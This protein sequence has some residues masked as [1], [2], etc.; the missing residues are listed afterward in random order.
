M[1]D[2]TK[3]KGKLVSILI[4]GLKGNKESYVGTI[5]DVNDDFIDLKC[6]GGNQKFPIERILIKTSLVESVW[7]Y[8]EGYKK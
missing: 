7:I 1:Y 4:T 8:K 2:F 5:L 6:V 3:L